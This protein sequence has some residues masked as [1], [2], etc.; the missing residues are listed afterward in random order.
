[1][2]LLDC[3]AQF[4]TAPDVVIS[5]QPSSRSR[6]KSVPWPINKSI[7]WGLEYCSA[8]VVR[9]LL[10]EGSC[11]PIDGLTE[12]GSLVFQFDEHSASEELAREEQERR[13]LEQDEEFQEFSTAAVR[14]CHRA[15]LAEPAHFDVAGVSMLITWTRL[16]P[17][18]RTVR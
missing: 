9:R 10:Y 3:S 18:Q 17:V 7:R 13:V 11:T 12:N 6:K 1:M 15:H 14:R 5:R 4:Y 16:M 8:Q 2:Q